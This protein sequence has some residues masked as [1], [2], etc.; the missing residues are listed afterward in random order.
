MAMKPI[1]MGAEVEYS[2]SAASESG[3][4]RR[5]EF[6]NLMLDAIRGQQ[7]WLPD[8][9]TPTGIYLENG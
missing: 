6:H 2:M 4:N 1:L 3:G 9:R 7:A 5:G 8:V